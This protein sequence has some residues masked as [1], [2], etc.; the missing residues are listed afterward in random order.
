MS[1]ITARSN[2]LRYVFKFVLWI[3]ERLRYFTSVP[4]S[5]VHHVCCYPSL[6]ST[7]RGFKPGIVSY[8]ATARQHQLQVIRVIDV[9]RHHILQLLQ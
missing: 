7:Q 2:L 8:L 9:P 4:A 1:A 3:Y 5:C 6:A